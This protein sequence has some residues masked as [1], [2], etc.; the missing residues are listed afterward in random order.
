MAEE[1]DYALYESIGAR[2]DP[3]IDSYNNNQEYMGNLNAVINELNDSGIVVEDNTVHIDFVMNDNVSCV[4]SVEVFVPPVEDIYP[5]L[6]LNYPILENESTQ[7]VNLE[8][9]AICDEAFNELT[10]PTM[11]V[12]EMLFPKLEHEKYC[13]VWEP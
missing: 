5:D 7:Q 8:V 3:I 12:G 4:P 11:Y 6:G 1:D 13:E 9:D 10:A 2:I